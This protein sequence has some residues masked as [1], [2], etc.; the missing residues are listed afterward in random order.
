MI[1]L[2]KAKIFSKFDVISAFHRALISPGYEDLTAF[3]T[4]FGLHEYK[5]IP[6]RLANA[7]RSFQKFTNNKLKGYLDEFCTAYIDDVLIFS[8]TIEHQKY[9]K[10]VLL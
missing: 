8:K 10:K 1:L 5:V 9:I 2:G 3:R 6:F 7:P 4:R